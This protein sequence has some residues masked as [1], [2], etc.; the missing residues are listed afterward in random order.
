MA[1]I[2]VSVIYFAQIRELTGIRQEEVIIDKE[3]TLTNLISKI[4]EN[5]PTLLKVKGNT[6]F[7]IN[8][9]LVRKNLSLKEGDQI[10]VFPPVAGG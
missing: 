1:T 10:A 7:A 6:Q 4:E 2:K 3:S 9:N 8:C 5:H